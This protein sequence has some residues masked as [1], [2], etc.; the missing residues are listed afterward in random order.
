MQ[1]LIKQ[2]PMIQSLMMF[3]ERV[4]AQG[5]YIASPDMLSLEKIK[6]ALFFNM[7]FISN[8]EEMI[9]KYDVSMVI[10]DYSND[11][12]QVMENLKFITEDLNKFYNI[13]ISGC[14]DISSMI[15]IV[16]KYLPVKK[17]EQQWFRPSR[18]FDIF[19]RD[20]LIE[21][22]LDSFRDYLSFLEEAANNKDV[23]EI[24]LCL[25]RIGKDPAIFDII[26]NAVERG[27]KVHVNI[28]LCASGEDIN[29]EWMQKFESIG[30][31]VTA[32]GY[33]RL[34]VHCKLTLV[35]FINGKSVAQIGTGNYHTKTTT[36]YTDLSL[37]T[38]DDSICHQV[39]KVFSILKGKRIKDTVFNSNFLVT[40][41]NARK[42]LLKLIKS[43]SHADGYICFKCNA[44]DDNEIIEALYKAASKG[45]TMD[46]IIRGV[47]TWLPDWNMFMNVH[48]KSIVWDKL[49]HSRVYCF[50]KKNPD[51]YIGSLDLVTHKIDKRIE[52]LVKV[53]D[54]QI[55]IKVAKYLNRYI[56]SQKG[57]VM[58]IY[59]KYVKEVKDGLQTT[60]DNLDQPR[61]RL[62]IQ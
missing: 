24:K 6:E 5:H 20:Q 3:N 49:E 55:L 12:D 18:Y 29:Y 16:E 35:K 54:P 30:C 27:V 13:D 11:C 62:P 26:N 60:N 46:L 2:I 8:T 43:Q 19:M 57:Y 23:T 7:V 28:E 40:R 15:S 51:I 36:Q 38:A 14:S 4:L 59:G 37:V 58:N 25:Y 9:S 48:I 56:T 1:K 22:P 10:D 21:Y 33:E 17:E 61:N 53:R 50:G 39:D 32:Y 42:A 34:K 41:Y 52:T 45:C 44:L 47:C 31:S